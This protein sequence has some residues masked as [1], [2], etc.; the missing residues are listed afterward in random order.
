MDEES[1]M[2]HVACLIRSSYFEIECLIVWIYAIRHQAIDFDNLTLRIFFSFLDREITN[3]LMKIHFFDQICLN[4][5][6][7]EIIA[8]PD[9]AAKQAW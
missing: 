8:F 7:A 5:D 6:T 4:P 2:K 1:T 9:S 3:H